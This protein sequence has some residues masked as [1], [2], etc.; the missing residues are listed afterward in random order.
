MLFVPPANAKTNA[1]AATA[2]MYGHGVFQNDLL[3]RGTTVVVP[4]VFDT[5]LTM[6]ALLK[7]L[8]AAGDELVD[9]D[10]VDEAGRPW[11]KAEVA[12]T[13]TSARAITEIRITQS[14]G[15]AGVGVKSVSLRS[16][17][18]ATDLVARVRR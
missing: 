12:T 14:S 3:A 6:E 15:L 16:R 8:L 10:A 11:A 5:A 1:T 2:M 13:N 7:I 18:H 9:G 17:R 4:M